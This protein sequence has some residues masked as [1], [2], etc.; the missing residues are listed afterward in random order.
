MSEERMTWCRQGECMAALVASL[1]DGRLVS[2]VPN[3]SVPSGRGGT[4]GLCGSS[5][6]AA[7]DPRRLRRPRR[8][9]PTGWE[10]VEWSVAITEIGASL[11]AIR[12]QSGASSIGLWAGAPVGTNSQGLTRTLAF[13]LGLGTPKLY[14]PLSTWGGPWVRAAEL[15]LGHPVALQGDIGR[16]HYVLLLGANQAATGWGPLQA[17]RNHAAD[18]VFSR[19]TKGTKVVAADARSTVGATGADLHLKIR[20]GTELF[21]LLGI[22]DTI[23]KNNWQD[24]QYVVDFT[25]GYAPLVEALKAWPVERVSGICGV[26]AEEIAGVALKFT[27]AAMALA[28]RSPQMLASEYGTLASWAAI[29]LHAIT[30]NLLRPG[31]LYDSKGVLDIHGIGTQLP[32]AKAPRTRVGDIPLLLLQAPGALLADD[33]RTPGEGQLRALISV[34][35]DPARD[36]PGGDRLREAL[37]GL[38]LLVAIDV[39]DNDTTALAHWVLPAT[40][41]WEREDLHLHDTSMLPYREVAWTPALVAPPGEARNEAQ[42]LADLF[43]EVGATVRGRV[44]AWGPH[45]RILGALLARQDLGPWESRALGYSGKT[46]LDEV[47]QNGSWQGGDVDR[48]TFR[49]TTPNG[50]IRLFPSEIAEA[51]ARLVPPVA[52]AGFD[53][54]LTVAAPRDAALR[55]FDRPADAPD[56]GVTLHP[57]LGFAEGASVRVVT[58]AGSVVATVRL[59]AGLRPDTVDFPAGYASDVMRLISTD[60]LDPF[61]GTP[62]L[63][64]QPCRV[65]PA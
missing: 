59:D 64:G 32:T 37:A 54:W 58:E 15:M 30:A 47:K 22:L 34:Q 51:L 49:V 27:R 61:T 12:S 28:H 7:E 50:K 65:E 11:K 44:S 56:P 4:C 21:L 39:A 57:D 43:G 36:L 2:L 20:P 60:R 31:G 48:A 40:H 63:A 33:V 18:L 52:R 38:D 35:G 3:E 13:A 17:G 5:L 25:E 10:E 9:T 62:A 6:H 41:P 23:V 14:S 45:L 16:A 55:R 46:T 1:Q 42:I 53:R 19:K 29:T 24:K 26:T 8:R